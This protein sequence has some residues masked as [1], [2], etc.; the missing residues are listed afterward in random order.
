[1]RYKKYV[2]LG[3]FLAFISILTAFPTR[4]A[5]DNKEIDLPATH[6]VV[7]TGSI[8]KDDYLYWNFTSTLADIMV[9]M[10]NNYEFEYYDQNDVLLSYTALLSTNKRSDSGWWR[11]PYSDTWNLIFENIGTFETHLVYNGKIDNDY[12]KKDI[13]P[14]DFMIGFIGFFMVIGI[15]SITLIIQH[16][17]MKRV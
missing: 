15:G 12:F 10:L 4:V 1:M 5:A 8:Q 16:S 3:S 9:M 13:L 7:V 2:L 14:M 17:K 6:Y 11:P